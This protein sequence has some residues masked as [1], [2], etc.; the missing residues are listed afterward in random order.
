[1]IEYPD[2]GMWHPL[3]PS[4]FTDDNTYNKWNN[5]RLELV[6]DGPTIGL[7]LQRSHLLPIS[8]SG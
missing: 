7:V 5:S 1:M 3:A 8:C 6:K 4:M 2:L